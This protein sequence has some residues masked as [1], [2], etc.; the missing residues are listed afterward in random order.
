MA[1]KRRK[2]AVRGRAARVAKQKIVPGGPLPSSVSP[3]FKIVRDAREELRDSLSF[4][5][6][7][8]RARH[9]YGQDAQLVAAIDEALRTERNVFGALVDGFL[10][11]RGVIKVGVS[12]AP[13]PQM[14]LPLVPSA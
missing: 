7:L 5:D 1:Q 14:T 6:T 3:D 2:V 11:T 13:E 12:T 4:S 9:F 8:H 10:A